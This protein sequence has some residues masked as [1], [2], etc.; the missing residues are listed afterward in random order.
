MS[1]VSS[2]LILILIKG[3]R[4]QYEFEIFL[5]NPRERK[6]LFICSA[7]G[8]KIKNLLWKWGVGVCLDP[9]CMGFVMIG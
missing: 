1:N 3:M 2:F 5:C 9:E 6:I 4:R 8:L 7:R